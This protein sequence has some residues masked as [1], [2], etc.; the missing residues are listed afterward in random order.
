MRK[1]ASKFVC[2]D[3]GI[4]FHDEG[5]Y[6]IHLITEHGFLNGYNDEIGHM[7]Q[8][9]GPPI[10]PIVEVENIKISLN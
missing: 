8:A 5:E 10:P 6:G 1:I 3:C 7:I 9:Q 4:E 2:K